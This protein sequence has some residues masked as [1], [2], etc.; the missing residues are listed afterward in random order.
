MCR[1][2][3]FAFKLASRSAVRSNTPC[4]SCRLLVLLISFLYR[5]STGSF[6]GIYSSIS[7]SSRIKLVVEVKLCQSTVS[8][9][10]ALQ[11][12]Y[13]ICREK[14]GKRR[15]NLL[16]QLLCQRCVCSTSVSVQVCSISV[17]LLCLFHFCVFHLL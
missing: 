9:N 2:A 4:W 5:S 14:K 10:A 17:P 12:S 16:K 8:V 6:D 15:S 7:K 1:S 13:A 11:K 3:W